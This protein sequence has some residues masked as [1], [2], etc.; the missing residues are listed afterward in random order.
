M[1]GRRRLVGVK[2]DEGR[3]RKMSGGGDRGVELGK[4]VRRDERTEES[5]G[6]SLG[7]Q[8]GNGATHF[9]SV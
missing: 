5:S 3:K 8:A 4:I 7:C 9:S 6:I 2:G 1:G